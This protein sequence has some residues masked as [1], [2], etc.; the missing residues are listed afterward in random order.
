MAGD[1]LLQVSGR[2]EGEDDEGPGQASGKLR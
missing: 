2:K 1:L